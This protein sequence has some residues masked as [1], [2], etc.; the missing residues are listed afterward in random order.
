M[1]DEGLAELL[2]CGVL[3]QAPSLRSLEQVRWQSAAGVV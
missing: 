2:D 3:T 1:P